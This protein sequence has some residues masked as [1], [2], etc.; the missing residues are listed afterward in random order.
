MLNRIFVVFC[1]IGFIVSTAISCS[2]ATWTVTALGDDVEMQTEW[3]FRDITF[4]FEN[5]TLSLNTSWIGTW[6]GSS[7]E[8][9]EL[10]S[11]GRW[12]VCGTIDESGYLL[13]DQYATFDIEN[14]GGHVRWAQDT[15]S[16]Y[17]APLLLGHSFIGDG[18][19]TYSNR[20]YENIID[21]TD[22]TLVLRDYLPMRLD[23]QDFYTADQY[24]FYATNPASVPEPSGISV[25][26]PSILGLAGALRHRASKKK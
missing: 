26:I 13:P 25:L 11:A 12:A 21:S 15:P 22:G 2:A 9:W 7:C 1:L 4:T 19:A 23:E 14:N 10:L 8:G 3:D 20:I 16:G 17:V 5:N 6:P 18:S 24:T